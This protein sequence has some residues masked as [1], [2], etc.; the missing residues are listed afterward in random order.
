MTKGEIIAQLNKFLDESSFYDEE[1]EDWKKQMNKMTEQD[2]IKLF[3]L[4][5]EKQRIL[6]DTN[7]LF[8][9]IA[10]DISSDR[11]KKENETPKILELTDL[12]I[13]TLIDFFKT[14][15]VDLILDRRINLLNSLDKYFKVGIELEENVN[16]EVSELLKAILDN[17]EV[18][19]RNKNYTE[20]MTISSWLNEYNKFK[21]SRKRKAIDRVNFSNN[22]VFA[23]KLNNEDRKVLLDLL[24]L[25]DFLNNPEE[26]LNNKD[27]NDDLQ[28]ARVVSGPPKT[29][30]ERKIDELTKIKTDEKTSPLAK[31]AADEEIEA[32][33]KIEDLKIMANKYKEGSLERK[34]IEDEI[35][36]LEK[37]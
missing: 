32:K 1:I 4:L 37:V 10:E 31:R 24:K 7:K 14:N 2:L 34:A 22:N 27:K 23:K 18:L 28:K 8:I 3:D 6:Q 20:K 19:F 36:R 30:E 21:E 12:S 5:K 9:K 16:A 13:E 29:V 33:K 26:Y 11:N 25:F 17:N 35:K 15:L